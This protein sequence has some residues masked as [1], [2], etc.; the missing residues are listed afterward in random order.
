MIIYLPKYLFV[1][2]E[3]VFIPEL[4]VEFK[5]YVVGDFIKF[6][7]RSSIC[8]IHCLYKKTSHFCMKTLQSFRL[9]YSNKKK[10]KLCFVFF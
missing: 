6:V 3:D 9:T 8:N 2:L 4:V 1:D 5:E 10:L 7:C